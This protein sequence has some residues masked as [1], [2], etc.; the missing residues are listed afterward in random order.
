MAIPDPGTF[1]GNKCAIRLKKNRR[2]LIRKILAIDTSGVK[3][4]EDG[5]RTKVYPFSEIA[6]VA[7]AR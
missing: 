7:L 1:I 2:P 3:V 4:E 6:Q 5:G